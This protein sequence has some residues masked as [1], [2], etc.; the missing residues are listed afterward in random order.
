MSLLVQNLNNITSIEMIH[1]Y[2]WD[3]KEMEAVSMRSL[4]HKLK[5]KLKSGMIIN[6][7]GEGYKLIKH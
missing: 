4:I 2:V 3:S 7:R 1:E 6:V 5:K